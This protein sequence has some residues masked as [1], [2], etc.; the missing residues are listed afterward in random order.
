V[1]SPLK[2]LAH[3]LELVSSLFVSAPDIPA[4]PTPPVPTV[5]GSPVAEAATSAAAGVAN[6]AN[7]SE[8]VLAPKGLCGYVGSDS[9]ANSFVCQAMG[10]VMPGVVFF[11]SLT[12]VAATL[13][14]LMRYWM[15]SSRL[16][17]ELEGLSESLAKIRS[18]ERD[19]WARREAAEKVLAELRA[20]GERV[21]PIAELA[22]RMQHSLLALPTAEDSRVVL[23]DSVETIATEVRDTERWSG[24]SL[25]EALP[26]W[27]TAIGLLTTFIAILLGLQGVKVLSN[28]EVRGIGGLVNG[29]SGKFFSSIIALGCAITITITSYFVSG[30]TDRLWG[31]LAERLQDLIPH[32]SVERVFLQMMGR[33]PGRESEKR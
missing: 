13:V 30:E 16:S 8:L 15:R 14:F 21:P 4:V 31:R 32:L 20:S 24:R 3:P 23:R 18:G 29:L 5:S 26:G 10:Q 22:R 7:G 1:A 11:V 19:E 17:A 33:G 2:F 28:L 6:A 27:L 12:V 9:G 25:A